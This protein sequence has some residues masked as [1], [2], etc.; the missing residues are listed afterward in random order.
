MVVEV[1][2]CC[3]EV[4]KRRGSMQRGGRMQGALEQK[5]CSVHPAASNCELESHRELVV[6]GSGKQT[7]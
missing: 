5:N 7:S 3:A 4:A 2:V 6:E 1:V